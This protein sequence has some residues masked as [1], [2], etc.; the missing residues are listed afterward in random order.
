M[1]I[2]TTSKREKE[3]DS[4]LMHFALLSPPSFAL[5]LTLSRRLHRRIVLDMTAKKEGGHDVAED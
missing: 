3:R 1:H 2:L 4:L 5:S